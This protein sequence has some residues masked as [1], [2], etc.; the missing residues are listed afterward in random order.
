[1]AKLVLLLM[2][3]NLKLL[4]FPTNLQINKILICLTSHYNVNISVEGDTREQ[5][6]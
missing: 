6:A 3:V 4:L 2:F 1:M 5:S